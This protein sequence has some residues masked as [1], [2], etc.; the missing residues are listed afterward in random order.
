MALKIVC[1]FAS[2]HSVYCCYCIVLHFMRVRSAVLWKNS[3]EKE[4]SAS[5]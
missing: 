2:C 4:A 5:A 3:R 1:L